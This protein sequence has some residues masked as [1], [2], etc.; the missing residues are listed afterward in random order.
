MLRNMAYAVWIRAFIKAHG[1][2][3]TYPEICLAWRRCKSGVNRRLHVLRRLGLVTYLP[4]KRQSLK[5][6]VPDKNGRRRA[7]FELKPTLTNCQVSTTELRYIC[8]CLNDKRPASSRS[9]ARSID[10]NGAITSP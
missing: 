2:G 8:D 5:A 9:R 10:Q 7:Y 1:Y 4:G 6:F 3:P